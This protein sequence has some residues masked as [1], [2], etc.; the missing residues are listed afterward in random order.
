MKNKPM[1]QYNESYSVVENCNVLYNTI[2]KF[3]VMIQ[4]ITGQTKKYNNEPQTK[5]HRY[6][7]ALHCAQQ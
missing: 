1:R 3:R 6:Q 5:D 4:N 2:D 7:D